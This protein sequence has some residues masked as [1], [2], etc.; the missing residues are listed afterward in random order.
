VRLLLDTHVV[1]WWSEQSRRLKATLRKQIAQAD[2]VF[3]SAAS[4]WEVNI[5]VSLG[6]LS[7]PGPLME[8]VESSGF[9]A[10]P[11]TFEHAEAVKGLPALHSDPFDRLLVAQA[12]VEGLHLVTSDVILA[13]YAIPVVRA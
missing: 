7:V 11:V 13:R 12:Q 9:S 5:K 1:L 2:E 10:L 6:K 8:V 3:V 4:A